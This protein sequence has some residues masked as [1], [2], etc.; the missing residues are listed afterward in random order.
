MWLLDKNGNEIKFDRKG[1]PMSPIRH[2]RCRVAA[3]R[4]FFTKDKA[5]EV[6]LQ[7]YPSKYDYKNVYYAQN[8]GNYLCLL[9]EG[10]KKGKIERKFRFLNYFDVASMGIKD[11][12]N[13]AKEPYFNKIEEKNYTLNLTAI[14][15]A[16]TRVLMWADSPEELTGLSERELNRRLFIVYKFNLKGANCIYLQ[17]HI[18]A[19][20]EISKDEDFTSFDRNSYQARLTLVANGFNCLI[21]ERDFIIDEI[22]KIEML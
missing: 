14:I 4:G 5:I 19:R 8:D 9:Y 1:R 6:K 15:K 11:V 2:V 13:L 21:E 17:N 3:G 18:E 16:G 20:N 10:V 7:T 22:G 12:K